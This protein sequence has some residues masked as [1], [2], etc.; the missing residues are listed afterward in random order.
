MAAAV[1]LSVPGS[2]GKQCRMRGVRALLLFVPN[3]AP[4]RPPTPH[5]PRPIRV[6]ADPALAAG[7][8]LLGCLPCCLLPVWAADQWGGLHSE[9]R[10]WAPHRLSGSFGVVLWGW[11]A[12][13]FPAALLLQAAAEPHPPCACGWSCPIQLGTLEA[14]LP[15]ELAHQQDLAEHLAGT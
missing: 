9:G 3:R 7:P 5:C 15:A 13:H 8:G 2:E 1:W 6:G 10:T 11:P 12:G 14:L 4:P